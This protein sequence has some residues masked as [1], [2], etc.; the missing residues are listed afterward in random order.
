LPHD[1]VTP[2]DTPV[3]NPKTKRTYR[4]DEYLIPSKN[5]AGESVRLQFRCMP[6]VLR[7]AKKFALDRRFNYTCVS[8]FLRDAVQQH[9]RALHEQYKNI[10]KDNFAFLESATQVQQDESEDLDHEF[11]I[12]AL[13]KNVLRHLTRGKVGTRTAKRLVVAHLELMRS[14]PQ[15]DKTDYFIAATIKRFRYLNIGKKEVSL[16]PSD[17]ERDNESESAR[18]TD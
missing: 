14:G 3:S 8:D 12:N 11:L 4:K 9:I 17:Q 7:E 2:I 6:R 5:E 13:E 18:G 15:S 10:D 16:K 1:N